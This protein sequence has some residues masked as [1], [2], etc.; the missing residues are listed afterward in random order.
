MG[1]ALSTMGL[2]VAGA[3]VIVGTPDQVQKMMRLREL[4]E[5]FATR[6]EIPMDEIRKEFDRMIEAKKD[7]AEI[8]L[9]GSD[10]GQRLVIKR[11]GNT[12][13]VYA[14]ADNVGT[15]ININHNIQ[16][17]VRAG[18]AGSVVI[19]RSFNSLMV[20][21]IA[22]NIG[23]VIDIDLTINNGVT[24]GRPRPVTVP[25]D[26]QDPGYQ[27]ATPKQRY[28]VE[29][30]SRMRFKKGYQSWDPEARAWEAVTDLFVE[31]E[32]SEGGWV[33]AN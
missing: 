27:T 7:A 11:S 33:Y 6:I 30:G 2:S 12:L 3:D 5:H 31:V 14:I 26:A 29:A 28:R 13:I 15:I 16:N 20:Y 9:R 21:V 19:D 8:P 23:T 1:F 25:M 24:T 4:S 17:F 22:G 18:T 32:F 10:N